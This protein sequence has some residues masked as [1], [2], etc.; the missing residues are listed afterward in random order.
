MGSGR[1]HEAK[2]KVPTKI[3]Q[4]LRD[5]LVTIILILAACS[6]ALRWPT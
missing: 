4:D 3:T 5:H 2:A 6:E 1:E